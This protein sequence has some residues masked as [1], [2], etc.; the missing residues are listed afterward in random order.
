MTLA[1]GAALAALALAILIA[2]FLLLRAGGGS[3]YRLRLESAQLLV[4]GNDVQIGGRPVGSIEGIELTSDNQAEVRIS[5]KDEAAPLHEGTRAVIRATSLSGI[6]NRYVALEPGPDSAPALDDGAVIGTDRTTSATN[7]DQLFDTLDPKARKDLQAVISGSARQYEGKGKEAN[8]GFR[9]FGPAI[10]TTA[11]LANELTRDQTSL[12]SLVVDTSR[13][14]GAIAERRDDLADLVGNANATTRAIAA[15][16]ASFERALGILPGTLRRAN[17]T[18]VN[19]RSTL[20]ALDP[21]V[22]ESKPATR[23]LAPFLRELRPLV[24]AARPTFRDLRLLIRRAGPN[25]D[26]VE[27]TR[28]TPRLQE[29]A[30]P[31]FTRARATLQKAQPVIDFIRPYSPDFIGWLRDFGQD[32]ANYDANGH[33]AR[34]AP[35]FNA[36][37][38]ADNPA[39]GVL[40]P[41]PPSQRAPGAQVQQLARCPGAASQARPDGSAPFLDDGKLGRD[42]CDPAIVPPGP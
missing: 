29:I 24:H 16:Q 22:R 9:Y 3:E 42:D 36:F 7:L 32:A 13:V 15:E 37:S 14:M 28:K 41:V 8:E 27:L 20:D 5:V 19:L 25:N 12:T 17:T 10:S 6:A 38:F 23:R 30:S 31:T 39:G 11:Q 34:I 40:T 35:Q 2:G 26:L 21:L 33:F 1:R 4:K 18:F